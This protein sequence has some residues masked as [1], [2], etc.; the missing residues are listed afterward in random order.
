M[1]IVKFEQ[2]EINESVKLFKKSIKNYNEV[3][4][5]GSI[6]ST[7]PMANLAYLYKS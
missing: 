6:I 4:G 1:G 3:L 5:Q 2:G 7:T